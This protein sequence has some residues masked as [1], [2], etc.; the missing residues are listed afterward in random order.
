MPCKLKCLCE[1]FF[2]NENKWYNLNMTLIKQKTEIIRHINGEIDM[3]SWCFKELING[4][5]L[6]RYDKRM[7]HECFLLHAR[8]LANFLWHKKYS[9]D[10][11]A[12]DFSVEIDKYNKEFRDI[13]KRIDKQL[14]H[15]V[16]DRLNNKNLFVKNK[17]IFDSIK[18]GLK[19]FNNKV[20]D[21]YKLLNM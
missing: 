9:D 8:N 11:Y 13:R 2:G 20:S 16:Y 15:I 3:F 1:G 18:L 5:F 12:G 21:E 7:K 6:D 4:N 14:S 19:E 17:F 10:V